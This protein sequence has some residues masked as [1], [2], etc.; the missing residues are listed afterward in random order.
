MVIAVKH[1]PGT[2][3]PQHER[4]VSVLP[5]LEPLFA[6]KGLRRGSVVRVDSASLALALLAAPTQE[7]LWACVAGMPQLCLAAASEMG[8]ALAR[9][10]VVRDCGERWAEVA[11][12]L[13]DGFDVVALRP[14]R[15]T[16][17]VTRRLEARV[18]RRGSV[19]VVVGEWESPDLGLRIEAVQ[20][21]GIGR[22]HGRLR[23]RYASVVSAG[24]GAAARPRRAQVWLPAP[25]G[26]V[27]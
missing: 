25:D 26:G 13:V 10:A 15:L 16:S 9:L 3:Q 7:G 11:A 5:P 24:R 22:G 17:V 27:A 23:A 1:Q 6:W 2:L 8:V 14:G 12:V 21:D 20:W 18:R 4:V 19:L